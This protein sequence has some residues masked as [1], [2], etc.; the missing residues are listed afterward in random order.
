MI[1]NNDYTTRHLLDYSY[2]QNCYKLPGRDLSSKI[3]MTIPQQFDSTR[4]LEGNNDDTAKII[5]DFSL[6]ILTVAE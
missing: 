6:Q 5:L 4:K 1:K 2:H 3:N